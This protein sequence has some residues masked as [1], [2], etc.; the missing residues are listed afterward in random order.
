MVHCL[1]RHTHTA[2]WPEISSKK[3][4]HKILPIFGRQKIKVRCFPEQDCDIVMCHV[5][6]L[7]ITKILDN[8]PEFPRGGRRSKCLEM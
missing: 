7:Q 8:I 2:D 4:M 3:I 6:R 1:D 5:P